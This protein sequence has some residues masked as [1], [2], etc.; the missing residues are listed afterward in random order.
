MG[1]IVVSENISLDGVVQDPTGEEGFKFGGWFLQIG[2][3]DREEWAKV[4]FEEA[5]GAEAFLLGRRSDEWLAARW[6]SRSGE[7]ADR[8]NSMPKYVVSATLEEPK[9]T[10]ATVLK[11]DVVSEVSK[12]RQELDGEIVVPAS[13]QLVRTLMEHDLVDELRL[14][15]FPVVLGSGG[16][17]FG[18]TSDK[19]PMRL[20]SARTIGDSLAL[21]TYELVKDA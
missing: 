13:R 7:W 4:G 12:L 18:E 2:D 14:I 20:L 16:R 5:V 11:G 6:L 17:L 15:V 3:K 8:L 9:W 10:N 19:K 21:L 1:K